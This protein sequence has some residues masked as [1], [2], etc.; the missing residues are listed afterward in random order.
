M[1]DVALVDHND[2]EDRDLS[3]VDRL[4]HFM[5][6]L[7]LSMAVVLATSGVAYAGLKGAA[8]PLAFQN[9]RPSLVALG[10]SPA[11]PNAASGGST[12][13]VVG[14]CNTSGV[15]V[16][17]NFLLTAADGSPFRN[18]LRVT[19]TEGARTL[20]A[21]S[22]ARLDKLPLGRLAAGASVRLGVRIRLA[23]G[24]TPAVQDAQAKVATRWVADVA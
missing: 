16:T 21:G 8:T 24:M 3:A 17:V 6:K 15:A 5:V 4:R 19:V 22:L 14:V 2:G 1:I 9:V 11:L 10:T 7:G 12:A 18:A 20:Y 13:S 23:A